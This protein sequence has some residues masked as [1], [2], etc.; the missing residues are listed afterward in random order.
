[1]LRIWTHHKAFP[2]TCVLVT[3][4]ESTALAESSSYRRF[5]RIK[6]LLGRVIAK[7]TPLRDIFQ[8]REEEVCRNSERG[9]RGIFSS[10]ENG[11]PFVSW[12]FFREHEIRSR[13][14]HPPGP[15]VD[16][17]V[18]R[19]TPLADIVYHTIITS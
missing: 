6:I 15:F 7:L 8:P 9:R 12:H 1:M 10:P 19:A 14:F 16:R 18:F 3:G 4:G 17:S 2:I 11:L 13:G 5:I